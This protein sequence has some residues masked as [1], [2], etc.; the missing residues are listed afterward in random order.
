MRSLHAYRT[1]S[2]RESASSHLIGSRVAF[3][4]AESEYESEYCV[5]LAV[6]EQPGAEDDHPGRPAED[7]DAEHA[8]RRSGR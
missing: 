6:C 8:F 7:H 2:R 4:V 3:G 5:T 1:D